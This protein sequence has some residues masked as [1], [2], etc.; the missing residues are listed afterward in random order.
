M[1]E[2]QRLV[3]NK[4]KA[5]G[6]KYTIIVNIYD[7]IEKNGPIEIK[8]LTKNVIKITIN[9]DRKH[10]IFFTVYYK[11]GNSIRPFIYWPIHDPSLWNKKINMYP[12]AKR[13]VKRLK[14]YIKETKRGKSYY[15]LFTLLECQNT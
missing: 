8:G 12:D 4:E 14:Y 7:Y 5:N 2:K 1:A 11:D 13:L 10:G 3:E 15:V 6:K 9:K